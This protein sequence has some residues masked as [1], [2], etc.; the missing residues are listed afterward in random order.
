MLSPTKN[1]RIQ[2]LFKAFEWLSSTFQG[3]F[4]YQGLFQESPLNSSS[5]KVCANPVTIKVRKKTRIRN[6][7]DQTPHITQDT[8]WESD[9]NAIHHIQESKEVSPFTEGNYKA[10]MNRQENMSN[11]LSASYIHMYNLRPNT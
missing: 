4:N 5:F 8:T 9:K 6:R 3:R 2:G 11:F 10:A 1:S 7:Y